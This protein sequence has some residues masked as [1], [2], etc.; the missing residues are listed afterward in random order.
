[1]NAALRS[2]AGFFWFDLD[3]IAA[4]AECSDAELTFG[5]SSKDIAQCIAQL[6]SNDK[7]AMLMKV[8]EDGEL[9]IVAEIRQ[10]FLSEIRG[11][12]RHGVT[13][14]TGSQRNAGQLVARARAINQDW[15]QK[16]SAKADQEKAKRERVRAAERAAQLN[17]AREPRRVSHKHPKHLV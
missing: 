4:A 8:I 17:L 7:D 2:L 10:H 13:S 3:L 9:H 1:L 6:P 16:E 15:R 14:Q 5:P 11:T 12:R